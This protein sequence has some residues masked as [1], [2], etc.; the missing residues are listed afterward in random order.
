MCFLRH[1][2]LL[3]DRR[4]H[5]ERCLGIC[6][7]EWAD[8]SNCYYSPN[9][10]NVQEFCKVYII[11]V[12]TCLLCS[13]GRLRQGWGETCQ[14]STDVMFFPLCSAPSNTLSLVP[15]DRNVWFSYMVKYHFW[16][17]HKN[18]DCLYLSLQLHLIKKGDKGDESAISY[19]QNPQKSWL[20]SIFYCE[21][22]PIIFLKTINYMCLIFQKRK[23]MFLKP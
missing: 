12:S 6:L 1:S 2:L 3:T 4:V 8:I 16:K 22:K 9:T 19:K 11:S 18:S 7:D 20:I 23:G 5:N 13:V 10:C 14:D 21:G 15:E 17:N